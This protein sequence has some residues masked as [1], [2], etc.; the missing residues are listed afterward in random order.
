MWERWRGQIDREIG[1]GKHSQTELAEN[2]MSRICYHLWEVEPIERCESD[3]P[4]SQMNG[5]MFGGKHSQMQS[6]ECIAETF[7]GPKGQRDRKVRP[8]ECVPKCVC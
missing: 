3:I 2:G 8:R 1:G 7:P 6:G 4:R 5:D